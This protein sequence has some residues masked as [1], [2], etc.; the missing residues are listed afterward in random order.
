M[1]NVCR[2]H[3]NNHQSH[4]VRYKQQ[5][6]LAFGSSHLL[7]RYLRT[8][9]RSTVCTASRVLSSELQAGCGRITTAPTRLSEQLLAQSLPTD[10]LK[11]SE[12]LPS[13]TIPTLQTTFHAF[14]R[15]VQVAFYTLLTEGAL[16]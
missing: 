6:L 11:L 16:G 12:R 4:N 13:R 7:L 2:S 15:N 9:A 14:T 8:L 5:L 10:V 1:G 3:E